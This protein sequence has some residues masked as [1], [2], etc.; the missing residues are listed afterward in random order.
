[1]DGNSTVSAKPDVLLLARYLLGLSGA[2]LTNGLTL[3]GSRNTP[4]L[5]ESYLKDNEY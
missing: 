1:M 3:A 5:I 4:S 2:A